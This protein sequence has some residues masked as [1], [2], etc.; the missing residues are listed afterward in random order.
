MVSYQPKQPTFSQNSRGDKTMMI[1][2]FQK[3]SKI[4]QPYYLPARVLANPVSFTSITT[5][6]ISIVTFFASDQFWSETVFPVP[7]GAGSAINSLS[8]KELGYFEKRLELLIEVMD[9][10]LELKNVKIIIQIMEM[11]EEAA[12]QAD[13]KKVPKEQLEGC[14][15]V[16][17]SYLNKKK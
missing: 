7:F 15:I 17:V 6:C 5:I 13:S 1:F 3:F 9:L 10:K 12:S 8:R 14:L 4:L 2:I 16:V 11:G